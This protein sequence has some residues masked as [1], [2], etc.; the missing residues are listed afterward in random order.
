MEIAICPKCNDQEGIVKSGI[1]NNKQRYLCKRCAYHFTVRKV[2]KKIDN[3]YIVK[4][5]QLYLEG[6]SLREIERVLGVSH[7]T[8]SNW[9][10]KYNIRKPDLNVYDPTYK[11]VTFEEMQAFLSNRDVYTDKGVIITE[12]G[13]KFLV[14]RW[15]KAGGN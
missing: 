9:I 2:G 14:I 8:I 1:V 10:K 3:Y 6:L 7:S 12:L 11:I 5:I 13:S 4:A 15:N